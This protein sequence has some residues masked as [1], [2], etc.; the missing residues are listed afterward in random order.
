MGG[1]DSLQ[2]RGHP[3]N[4][5][6]ADAFLGTWLYRGALPRRLPIGWEAPRGMHRRGLWGETRQRPPAPSQRHKV[7]IV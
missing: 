2:R 1:E 7:A 5:S 6:M 4:K 3:G